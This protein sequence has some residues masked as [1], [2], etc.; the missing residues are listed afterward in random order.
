[1]TNRSPRI[2]KHKFI[3]MCSGV[4]PVGPAPGPLENEKY[5]V[6]VLHRGRT[7]TCY[8]TSRSHGVQKHKFGVTCPDVSLVG[9]A[10][11]PSELEK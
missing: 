7:R 1:M 4:L 5:C 3:V 6:D 10:L 9:P 11:G 2:Q 8:V